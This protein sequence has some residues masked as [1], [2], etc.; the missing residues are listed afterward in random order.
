MALHTDIPTRA[1]IEGLLTARATS[2]ISLYLPTSPLTQDAQAN[3]IEL[4]NLTST[5]LAQLHEAGTDKADVASI[6]ES[7][8]ELVDDD[9]FWA[10]QAHSLAVF[11]TPQR[12][13]TFRLPNRLAMIAEVSD[14]FHLKPLLRAVTFPQAAFVLALAQGSARLLEITADSAPVEVHVHDM[15]RDAGNANTVRGYARQVD[16]ALRS[17]LTGSTCP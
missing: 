14:R 4:K 5:A 15:P 9:E 17:V 6:E 12:V 11:A 13:Q 1:E 10:H 16:H 3:R 8:H 2:S 7:L